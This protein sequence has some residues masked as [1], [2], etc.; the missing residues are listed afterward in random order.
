MKKVKVPWRAVA[1]IFIGFSIGVFATFS[2]MIKNLPE[3]QSIEF[4]DWKIKGKKD[5]N[6]EINVDLNQDQDNSKKKRRWRD[7]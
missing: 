1:M 3:S 5:A 7:R 2:L 6:I 4:G